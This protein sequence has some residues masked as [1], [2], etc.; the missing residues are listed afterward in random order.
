PRVW[1]GGG[2]GASRA[3]GA[4][5]STA[6]AT[7]GEGRRRPW[8]G[9]RSRRDAAPPR[10]WAAF[11]AAAFTV[12]ALLL[13]SNLPNSLF[14][15]YAS[16]YRLSPLGLTLLFATYTLLVIPAVLLF[17]P[18]SDVK[19]RR[20]VMVVAIGV[21]G[22]A[23]ALFAAARNVATLFV[24]QGVQAMAMGALQGSAAPTLTDYDPSAR[25]RRAA[26]VASAATLGG[27]AAGPVLGG[28]LAQYAAWPLR[29]GF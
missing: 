19:G 1:E 4:V 27:A 20:E 15:L 18:L 10:G 7:R 5:I 12:F 24:A 6:V 2:A 26:M 11:S 28:V 13:G 25:P 16:V 22:L 8:P 9:P 17:G 3:R 21:A 23:I 14:P 29:L